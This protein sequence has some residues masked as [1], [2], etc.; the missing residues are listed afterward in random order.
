MKTNIAPFFY[1]IRIIKHIFQC[2]RMIL[3]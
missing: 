3:V 2:V 1:D